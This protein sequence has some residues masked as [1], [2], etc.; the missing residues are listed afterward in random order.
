M[1]CKEEHG[2]QPPELV[3]G[4]IK[5]AVWS[6]WPA[7]TPNAFAAW[8]RIND[9]NLEVEVGS[10]VPTVLSFREPSPNEPNQVPRW[11]ES[12]SPPQL[13]GTGLRARLALAKGFTMLLTTSL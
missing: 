10:T 4:P 2:Y 13:Q 5:L 11:A 3:A 1:W 9:G 8:T 6:H 12:R 7:G